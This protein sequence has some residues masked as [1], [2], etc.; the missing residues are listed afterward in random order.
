MPSRT[1]INLGA[2]NLAASAPADFVLDA[3]IS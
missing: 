1:V 2:D 3:A